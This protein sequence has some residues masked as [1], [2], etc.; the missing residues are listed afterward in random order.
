MGSPGDVPSPGSLLAIV[1]ALSPA[2]VVGGLHAGGTGSSADVGAPAAVTEDDAQ[3]VWLRDCAVCH[4]TNGRGTERGTDLAGTGT[5]VLDYVLRTGRMPI[6]DPDDRIRRGPPAYDTATID[7]LVEYAAELDGGSVGAGP[8]IPEVEPDAGDAAVGGEIWRLQCAA[9]HR[10]SG[11]GGALTGEIAPD[12]RP[13]DTRVFGE[14]VRGGPFAMPRFGQAALDDD[15]LNDLAAYVE[16]EIDEPEDR[17]GWSLAHI[18]PVAE[19]AAAMV[20]GLGVLTL[21]ARALGT[22]EPRGG[23]EEPE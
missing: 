3:T 19:G 2:F 6:G 16:N 4:G 14:A 7:A 20:L 15:E 8:P 17:G 5:A 18:G 9:C 12:V 1:V 10:W 23:I 13:A 21:I 22:R 11:D